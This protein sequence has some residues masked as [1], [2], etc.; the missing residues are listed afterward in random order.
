[1]EHAIYHTYVYKEII[2]YGKINLFS[3]KVLA[4]IL[5]KKNTKKSII[6]KSYL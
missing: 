3:T 1:M 4:Y 5:T 6:K 2:I